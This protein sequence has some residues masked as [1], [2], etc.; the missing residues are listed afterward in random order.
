[1][2]KTIPRSFIRTWMGE[3]T[4]LGMYVRSSEAVDI[5]NGWQKKQNLAPLW[6][7]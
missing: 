7:R 5:K 4:E 3:S 6:K 2:G 1:M